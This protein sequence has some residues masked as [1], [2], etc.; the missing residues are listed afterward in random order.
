VFALASSWSGYCTTKA[1]VAKVYR[2][3]LRRLTALVVALCLVF[4]ITFFTIHSGPVRR[5]AA[6]RITAL[7]AQRQIELETE[8][9]GY[10]LLNAS[11]D[12]RNVRV[13]SARLPGAPVFATIGR[14]RIDLSLMDLLR[15]RYI[16]QSGRV[17][18]VS[19]HYFVDEQG[20]DNLPTMP[21]DPNQPSQPIDYLISALSIAD[22]RVR[23]EN[24]AQQID[25][26]LP[27]SSLD[28]TGNRLTDRHQ[29]RFTTAPGQAR[30]KDRTAAIERIL[31]EAEFGDED[32]KVARLEI[33]SE[34][35]R[36]ELANVS[37]DLTTR[38]AEV[39]S[40]TAKGP[41]GDVAGNGNIALDSSGQSRVQ[42][43]LNA[44]DLKWLMDA[45]N[46][47][48][49][50][51]SRLDGKVQ[52]EWPGLE[53][54]K[55]AGNADATLTPTTTTVSSSTMP[56]E[57]RVV[58]RGMDGRLDAQVVRV[59]AAGAQVAGRV[60]VA[61]DRRLNGQLTGQSGDIARI[62]SSVEAFLGRRRG[63]LLPTPVAGPIAIDTR[64]AGTV[65]SPSAATV[66]KAPSLTLGTATGV[67]LDAD[68]AYEPSAV[69]IRRADLTWEQ[70]RAQIDGR[71]G[72]TAAKRLD[73]KFT[74]DNMEVPWL[75]KMANHEGIPA[76]GTLSANGT[77]A[78]TTN[79]PSAM[80]T[81]QGTELVAYAEP[82][83]T[84][85]ANIGL[86]GRDVEVS[87]LVIEKPQPDQDGRLS[88]TGSYNLDRRSYTLDL[89]SEGLR[90][91]GLQLP[92]GERVRGTIEL[93]GRGSGSVAS[94]GG[95]LDL[96]ID[97]LEIERP[98]GDA[99]Q[100]TPIGRVVVNAV[101][102][103][104]QA[105]ITASADRFNL[106]AD[107]LIALARPWPTT[108]KVRAEN[109][110]LASLPIG[111]TT[112][113]D[114]GAPPL[115]GQLRA[116]IDASGDLVAPEKGKAD[117]TIES[118]SGTWYGRPFAVKGPSTV[119]YA[120]E[121]LDIE[122]LELEASGSTLTVTGA[123][124]LTDRA[125]EGEVAV[126]FRGNL[127]TLTQY[128]PPDTKVAG[129]GAVA[130]TGTIKGTL[131]AIDPDL[132]V[133]VENGLI[134][135]PDL[136][137]GFSNIEL[138]ARVAN[139]EAIV[140]QLTGNWGSA[141]VE[142]SGRIP[143]EAVPPLPVEIPRM[144]GPST[145]KAAVKGLNP[146]AIPGASGV[147][148]GIVTL[149]A[150]L[151]ADRPDL[152]ALDG[153]VT[154]PELAITFRGLEL[155]QEQIS[156]I[157][158]ASGQATVDNF[159]LAGSA[160]TIAATGSVELVGD[161][162][163]NVNVDGALNAGAVSVITDR[164]RAEGDTTLKLQARGTVNDPDLRGTFTLTDA[165]AV[166][167][168]PNLAAENLNAEITLEGSR[169]QIA[170]F[171]GDVNG[172]TL[173]GSGFIELGDGGI[174]D[175]DVRVETK[176]FAYDAPLGMRSLTDSALRIS[177]DGT[178]FLV[179]GRVT[180]ME[181]GLTGDMN[182]DSGLLAAMTARRKLDLTEDRDTFL[183]RLRFD[184][185][186]NTAT[187]ILVD[188]NLA[189][190]EARG[191]VRIVGTPYQP[192][193]TGQVT[194]LEGGE[195]RLNERRYEVE[196]GVITFVDERRISPSFDLLLN[197][198]AGNYDINISVTGTP[199]DTDTTLTS[200]PALPEPDIMAMLVTGRTLDDMRG[201]EF[202][203][204]REQ[205]LSYLAGRVGSTLG[206]GLRQAT[207]LSEVRIEPTL[208][209]NE[210]DPSA[211][212]TLGQDLTDDLKLVYSTNLTDSNDQIWVAEYDVTRRFQTRG[213]RQSDATY[214]L[215]FRHDVRFGG[216][217]SPRRQPR[218]RPK[219]AT[220]T[221][222]D[223]VTNEPD[224]E[225]RAEFDVKE[226]QT[227]DF[228]AIREEVS[229]VEADLLAL[230]YM[231]SRIRLERQVEGDKANLTL[232]VRRGPLVSMM[233]AGTTPPRKVQD[234]VRTQWHR[235]VFDKQRAE[236]GVEAL[237]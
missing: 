44:V 221:V 173:E 1:G 65:D 57:G 113:T 169:I 200:D 208:I 31:G 62:V 39:A 74:A 166:S 162:S 134:L 7:L 119:E 165:N 174:S 218:V 56:V 220:V 185:N 90:L 143:L 152:A 10:N 168:E 196:R 131:K 86:A 28:V 34:G 87:R 30:V 121:R 16:V 84:L 126:D 114:A 217:A 136:E 207:G 63:S 144:G 180:L 37:Y 19:I 22:A 140:E 15:G 232:R 83:G 150:D 46:L 202:E 27:L 192:G 106:N 11:L 36:A 45:F 93:A 125:G 124:P 188:N 157:T 107:A 96:T 52:A 35:S 172:G 41:W 230:G 128:L 133:T 178:N 13:R 149:Q 189:R 99:T 160:G 226:G 153:T 21:R 215:D 97:G 69:T 49:T 66:I 198:S 47:P 75:L 231:Q 82:I 129:D 110:D 53:Y 91:V 85:N 77:I 151:S 98:Q 142:A 187:P 127:A 211:R 122:H 20:R 236:D 161:R 163:L 132:T 100:T 103:N 95:T 201:E 40:L 78:G 225:V 72:L 3:T 159:A 58:V 216:Q 26:D 227:Y 120:D 190:A 29:V 32:V 48:Y 73:L 123:L 137:P 222:V 141:T 101:A 59:N 191:R 88:A 204:A 182:F 109:L 24:R 164:V 155:A 67:A 199:G 79:R 234:E 17:E 175:I 112:A 177:R 42:A 186:V 197:T 68:V 183:E 89:Q 18:N 80:A 210:T 156:T 5:Y 33:D 233:F 139:G 223:R 209:A 130:L 229:E 12:L 145:L 104:K 60:A 213:V 195:V 23:Y 116:T 203:V 8:E 6:N 14:A 115:A 146:A 235:G 219:V 181:A 205:V 70:A 61:E 148:G 154:F 38:R 206:R 51:A 193:M 71:V 228:F 176:D 237:R 94:P 214:R 184:V 81:V 102:E 147:L 171:T 179:S 170:S 212:L 25:V 76:S 55:A 118:L 64:I 224:P 2:R 117:A 108:V 43:D 92:G 54:L 135:S 4:V 111:V 9:L 138:R 167:D 194:L 105:T 158:L 50:V